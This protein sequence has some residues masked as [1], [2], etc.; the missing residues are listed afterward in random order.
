VDD[1]FRAELLSGGGAPV[2][3]RP[4]TGGPE[5]WSGWWQVSRGDFFIA[6]QST[7]P[8]EPLLAEVEVHLPNGPYRFAAWLQPS[9]AGRWQVAAHRRLNA[10]RDLRVAV[11]LA[12]RIGPTG[13]VARLP[14]VIRDLSAAGVGLLAA[15]RLQAGAAYDLRFDGPPGEWIGTLTGRPVGQVSGAG[16]YRYGLRLEV[17]EGLRERLYAYLFALRGSRTPLRSG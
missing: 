14:V 5:P 12:G 11:D 16:P 2:D 17:E 3:V 6:P 9:A 10:R 1:R 7:R 15:S 8:A 13:E 4:L